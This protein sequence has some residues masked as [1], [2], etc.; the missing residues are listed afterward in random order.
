MDL[1]YPGHFTILSENRDCLLKAYKDYLSTPGMYI[2]FFTSTTKVL[3]FSSI[4]VK[5]PGFG[6]R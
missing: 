6:V 4:L 1:L 3:P 5:T 2:T